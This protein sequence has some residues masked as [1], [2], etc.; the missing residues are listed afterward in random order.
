[1]KPRECCRLKYFQHFCKIMRH[2]GVQEATARCT[3]MQAFSIFLSFWSF[4]ATET[5]YIDRQ[6]ANGS[7]C[8]VCCEGKF[9]AAR[10]V[11]KPCGWRCGI[12]APADKTL[13]RSADVGRSPS[14]VCRSIY[15][16]FG[17]AVRVIARGICQ[18]ET[19]Q[20]C[21]PC[22]L[23]PPLTARRHNSTM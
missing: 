23:P 9:R 8:G 16:L 10:I 6:A 1:M 7:T 2:P 17:G 21:S 4:F 20:D 18:Q 19:I 13:A 14:R 12:A 11:M 15:N 22:A 5:N 3:W